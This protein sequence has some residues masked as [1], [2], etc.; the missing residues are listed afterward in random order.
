M[1]FPRDDFPSHTALMTADT[2]KD[3][4]GRPTI[5]L[6]LLMAAQA[7]WFT[8]VVDE[9]EQSGLLSSSAYETEE[10]HFS[11][12]TVD[13][14]A[15]CILNY[16]KGS[17]LLRY[18][19][20]ALNGT[21][22][23]EEE[24]F[25]ER[26]HFDC[27]GSLLGS[28]LGELVVIS[29]ACERESFSRAKRVVG[30]ICLARLAQLAHCLATAAETSTDIARKLL[31]YLQRSTISGIDASTVEGATLLQWLSFLR[32]ASAMLY[33]YFKPLAGNVC[34]MSSPEF[35]AVLANSLEFS[36]SNKSSN[37]ISAEL[38]ESHLRL[39]DIQPLL[40][41]A[42]DLRALFLEKIVAWCDDLI[43]FQPNFNP[44]TLAPSSFTCPA[45]LIPSL[46]SSYTSL[47]AD[48][49]YRYPGIDFPALCLVCGTVMDASGKGLV[50]E[51]VLKCSPSNGIVFLV[52][53]CQTLLFYQRKSC[54]FP[55]FYVDAHGEAKQN[56][57]GR[58]LYLDHARFEFLRGLYANHSIARE[59]Y[60]K[61][62]SSNRVIIIGH[63]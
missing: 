23:S 46:P 9:A 59:V 34:V 4:A 17:Y 45:A 37:A 27:L 33:R 10:V 1:S 16:E 6:L 53:D 52:H 42:E 3:S 35:A 29:L 5:V 31:A 57:H 43:A 26:L 12:N 8:L 47:H 62:S 20:A 56:M 39:L 51:H 58:P 14:I 30:W 54:Y 28:H 49:S 36:L 7:A 32:C 13:G 38:V 60:Y 19:R 50:T 63:Y 40:S 2:A 41:P 22:Q 15:E 48:I 55:S 18:F 21:L 44:A 11:T 24:A 61:R 25:V